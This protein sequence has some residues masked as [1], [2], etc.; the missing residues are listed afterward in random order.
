MVTGIDVALVVAGAV[1]LFGG[2]ALSIYGVGAMG[3][4]LGGGGGF[5]AAPAIG[6][7]VGLSGPIA[8]VAAVAIGAIAGIAVT[9]VLL[10]MAVASIAFIV[11]TYAG[12]IVAEPL[13][14]T[15]NPI[16]TI[17]AAIGIGIAAA[18]LG[19][20]LTR[21][22]M[23]VITSFIGAA[24]A[25]RIVTVE[26]LQTAQSEVT[27]DPIVFDPASPIFLGLA[28]L[29]VLSQFGLFK[30]GYVAKL[31][32]WLPGAVMFTDGKEED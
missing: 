25:S 7:A 31:V 2:A 29:G 23:I 14:G 10:S 13:V 6:G 22:T 27:L 11:G 9:Y 24:L 17:P 8:V 30:L 12:L 1:L 15:A 5:L 16:L 3:L 18:L 26:N 19:T 20:F 32:T 4:L 21:T 28:V